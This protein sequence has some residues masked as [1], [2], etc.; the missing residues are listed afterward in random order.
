[1]SK[2]FWDCNLILWALLLWIAPAFLRADT[3]PEI[4]LSLP[5]P[6]LN[7]NM[8]PVRVGLGFISGAS[9]GLNQVL[10]HHPDRFFD[11]YP[12]ANRRF[13]DNQISWLNKYKNNDPRQGPAFL[14]STDLLVWTTDAPHLTSTLSNVTGA[15]S[16]T[17]P[18]WKG[19]KKLRHYLAEVGLSTIGYWAGFH[20]VYSLWFR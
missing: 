18:L 17:I 3:L 13:W 15:A 19:N 9:R 8:V 6:E 4:R 5:K 14:F 7:T 20:S 12:N 2:G 16:F 1:M 10:V 11:R